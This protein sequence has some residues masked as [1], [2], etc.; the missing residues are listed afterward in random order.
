[1]KVFIHSKRAPLQ[2]N[3]LLSKK[4]KKSLGLLLGLILDPLL[5]R[6]GGRDL[7]I[8]GALTEGNRLKGLNND[9]RP[10]D[11]RNR[12]VTYGPYSLLGH[13]RIL[14]LA[15]PSCPRRTIFLGRHFGGSYFQ[16]SARTGDLNLLW[17]IPDLGARGSIFL[18]GRG[19]E[20]TLC[21]PQ[22]GRGINPSL[23]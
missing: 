1:M 16:G 20:H 22:V 11:V 15:C 2:H 14:T 12:I 7:G 8:F 9:N 13:I 23:F 4:K 6:L 10:L 21:L 18:N 17:S 3:T 5:G 19:I